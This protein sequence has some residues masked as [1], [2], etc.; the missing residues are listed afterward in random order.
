MFADSSGYGN[1]GA[2]TNME[3]ASDWVWVP[4]LGRWGL[5]CDGSNEY[6]ATGYFVGAP[7]QCTVS[8]WAKTATGQSNNQYLFDNTNGSTGVTIR[9]SSSTEWDGFFYTAGGISRDSS[10]GTIDG[11]WH[12]LAC[13]W[14]G[15]DSYYFQDGTQ[16]GTSADGSGAIVSSASAI[17]VAADYNGSAALQVLMSDFLLYD[18]ALSPA[19]IQQL[20]DP[21]NAMLSGLLIPP[22]RK[23]WAVS[24]AAPASIIP[25]IMHHRRLM[26]VA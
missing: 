9:N 22:R 12:H 5:D 3:P 7:S 20:A 4:E 25:R 6:V 14:D 8:V 17:N 24:G 15:S 11:S 2:L 1:H 16:A 10:W 13:V 19:E 21:S 26:Q 18:R 23:L